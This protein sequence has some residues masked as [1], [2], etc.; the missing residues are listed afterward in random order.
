MDNSLLVG[1]I[2][3]THGLFLE[4][5]VALLLFIDKKTDEEMQGY[6]KL[7]FLDD[8]DQWKLPRCCRLNLGQDS[9]RRLELSSESQIILRLRHLR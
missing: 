8:D 7:L 1:A 3:K 9:R 4:D 6:L 2:D 5:E